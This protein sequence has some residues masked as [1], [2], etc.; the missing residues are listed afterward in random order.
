MK[1]NII[2]LILLSLF[3]VS[4]NTIKYEQQVKTEQDNN[5]VKAMLNSCFRE[6]IPIYNSSMPKQDKKDSIQKIK[7]IYCTKDC[8]EG[9]NNKR[10]NNFDIFYDLQKVEIF[11]TNR[12]YDYNSLKIYT[13]KEYKAKTKNVTK[14]HPKKS[15][16][17]IYIIECRLSDKDTR[18]QYI[19]D[20]G[21]VTCFYLIT[22]DGSGYKI[23]QCF[24]KFLYVRL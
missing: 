24:M 9:I 1:R 2:L 15:Q 6:F 14:I 8:I 19:G 3:V 5:Q 13:Y 18:Y 7:E 17:D 23:K 10:E 11:D 12:I 16:K 20:F 21:T 22:K 4:C